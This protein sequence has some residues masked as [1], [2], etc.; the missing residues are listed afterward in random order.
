MLGTVLGEVILC[1]GLS[2]RSASYIEK[3]GGCPPGMHWTSNIGEEI[4]V[5]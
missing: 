5:K 3:R 4:T 1:L 2:S